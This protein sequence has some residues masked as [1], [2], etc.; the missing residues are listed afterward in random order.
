M[1]FIKPCG[2]II[3]LKMENM[4]MLMVNSLKIHIS[5]YI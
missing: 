5:I 1:I 3:L 2:N 4:R